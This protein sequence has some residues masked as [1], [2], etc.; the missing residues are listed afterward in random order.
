MNIK[1][2]HNTPLWVADKAI[3][4]CWDKE[5]DINNPNKEKID[6]VA[7]KFKHQSTIEHLYYNFEIKGISRALLQEL[8]RHRMASYSVKST[9]YT[10]K[11]LKFEDSFDDFDDEYDYTRASKYVVWT[12]IRNVDITTFFMLE[13]LRSNV[14]SGISNDIVKYN[15][16]ESYKTELIWSINARSLKNFLKLRTDK[17][18]LWEIRE[19]AYKIYDELPQDHKFLFEEEL[20][21]TEKPEKDK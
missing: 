13:D 19:L 20:Y 3:S 16:P 15:L 12:G 18:A 14:Q 7:N 4:K 6:R 9:R 17:A 2:L 11:E 5:C 8:A 1:L 21:K 10:L